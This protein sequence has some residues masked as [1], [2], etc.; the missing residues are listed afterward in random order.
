MG[1]YAGSWLDARLF[2]AN[3]RRDFER[4]L[5]VNPSVPAPPLPPRPKDGETVGRLE[6]PRLRLSVMVVEGVDQG[7]LRRAA[8]HIPG[9]A[10]PGEPG[11]VGIAAHRD[12]F[13]RPLNSIRANDTIQF[14]T[15]STA[16]RYRVVSTK[17]V[18]PSDVQ[19]LRSTGDNSLT[20]VTCY[21]FQYVGSAPERFIVHAI[22]LPDGTASVASPGPAKMPVRRRHPG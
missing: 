12:T 4:H 11:N 9:T 1:Y 19:V 5:R 8:G 7:D 22:R 2:Q 14:R 18:K 20:L 6:I 10:L 3:A 13:F 15:L 21:P 17:I 16:Y